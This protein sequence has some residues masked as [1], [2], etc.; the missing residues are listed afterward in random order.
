[1]TEEVL[2]STLTLTGGLRFD[3]RSLNV[4]AHE[5]LRVR[6]ETRT[7]NAITGAMGLAWQPHTGLSLALNAGRAWRSPVLIEL[8]GNGVHEGT[9]RF[10]RGNAT[11]KPEESRSL[12]LTLRWL[13]RHLYFE[14]TGFVNR[15]SDYIFAQ[16][17]DAIDPDSGFNIL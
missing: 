6:T 7:Y 13:N 1:M 15:I 17:T 9:V 14:V 4:E 8:F 5:E 10:E 11:L 3:R 12:D 16:R 2:L